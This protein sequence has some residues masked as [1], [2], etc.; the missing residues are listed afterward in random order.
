MGL[1]ALAARGM[2]EREMETIAGWI[3]I[4]I[5]HIGEHKLPENKEERIEYLKKFRLDIRKDE[6]LKG[7]AQ[8]VKELCSKYP[9]EF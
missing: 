7:I 4:V 5:T 2:T 1:K 6:T 9:L 3:D 8:E